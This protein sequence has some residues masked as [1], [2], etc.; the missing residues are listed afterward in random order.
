VPENPA[1]SLAALR[2]LH[3]VLT[4]VSGVRG[5]DATLQAVVDGVVEGVGF[6]IA[7]VNCRRPDGSFQMLAVSGS[8]DAREALLGRV[9]APDAYEKEFASADSW[10][11]L[12]FVPHERVEGEVR[13]WVPPSTTAAVPGGW[14]P[15]D[16]L[17]A[18]LYAASG[19][20]VGV[21][22]V[23]L[24]R[25]GAR[26]GMFQRELLE[27]FAAQAGIAI[28][29]A[30]LTAELR[31]EHELL[32]ASE[33]SLGLA[34]EGS[35]V[36]MAMIDLDGGHPGRFLRANQALATM[37]GYSVAQ[38]LT[39]T[40]TDLTH[41][42]DAADGLEHLRALQ[43]GDNDAY[44]AENRYVR[45]DG[46]VLW[47]GVTCSA[48]RGA[49]GGACYGYTQIEDITERHEAERLLTE[50]ATHDLLTG[51]LNRAALGQKLDAAIAAAAS[52]LS[53][54]AVLFCDLD[55]MK[56]VNDL[57]GHEAG[58]EVLR[59]TAARLLASVRTQDRVARF[60]GDEFV[61]LLTD[62]TDATLHTLAAR[63]LRRLA[64]P[65]KHDG[66]LLTVTASIGVCVLDG[67]KASG[68]VLRAADA[69]MYSAKHAGRDRYVIAG[70]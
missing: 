37:T 47:V 36:G 12:R 69:A 22:S 44:R 1:A 19:E 49:P 39:M 67:S 61:L 59:S 60:G 64:E 6:G 16:A 33:Q 45:S 53:R 30:R 70:P 24:P 35:D 9:S 50:A 3:A 58:D 18:P 28:D 34:F 62:V 52:G 55:G 21:L 27:M 54:G 51:L 40:C 65:I 56:A 32:R 11:S 46:S 23:D 66:E 41:P 29:N 20:L 4:R 14:H 31:R 10:G 13:G 5:L 25:D 8:A 38:I 42:A 48:I 17:F 26:P 43:V 7:A 15:E 68:D 63:I 57:S 2:G